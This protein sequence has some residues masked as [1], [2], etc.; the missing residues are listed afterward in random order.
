M[1]EQ[2]RKAKGVQLTDLPLVRQI[3]AGK[4]GNVV[5][6]LLEPSAEVETIRSVPP[7]KRGGTLSIRGAICA[8]QFPISL[9][10]PS[11]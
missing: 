6:C 1:L 4:Q 11:D 5:P 2:R 3:A 9:G 7:Y 10:R 8:R